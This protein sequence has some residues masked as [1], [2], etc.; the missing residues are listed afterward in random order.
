[1]NWWAPLLMGFA[2]SF[3]CIGMCGPI[4]MYA[5]NK[6][7][8]AKYLFNRIIYN[9]GRV[10]TY[11]ILGLLLGLF[12][13]G[14]N[15][16]G[17]QQSISIVAGIFLLL[18]VLTTF[19]ASKFQSLNFISNKVSAGLKKVFNQLIQQESSLKWLGLGLVNGVLPCGFVYLAL[20]VAA[21]QVDILHTVTFM[22]LFGAG[23][24]PAM[25][26]VTLSAGIIN[27]NWKNKLGR[28]SP[29]LASVVAVLLILRGLNLGIPYISPAIDHSENGMVK[30]ECCKKNN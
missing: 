2:G 3:H 12:G 30:L 14:L 27:L 17:F 26:A 10:V 8:A 20:G 11:S 29:Y 22:S 15:Y 21:F 28:I 16:A 7:F 1:M 6:N 9:L 4:A 18:F 5:G 13:A 25:L 19:F 24:I 23:T